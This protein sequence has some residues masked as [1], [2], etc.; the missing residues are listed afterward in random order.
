MMYVGLGLLHNRPLASAMSE[1]LETIVRQCLGEQAIAI[2]IIS[3]PS[4]YSLYFQPCTWTQRVERS[5]DMSP[6]WGLCVAGI[7]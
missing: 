2:S 3:P 4:I 7:V 6:L 1:S 5:A